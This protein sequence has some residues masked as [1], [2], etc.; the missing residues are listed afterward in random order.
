MNISHT[1]MHID[2]KTHIYQ[3]SHAY[4]SERMIDKL[5]SDRKTDTHLFLFYIY[6]YSVGRTSGKH[7]LT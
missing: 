4:I 2:R 7:H 6:E 3:S 5:I 1:D